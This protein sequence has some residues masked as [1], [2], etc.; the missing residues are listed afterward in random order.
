MNLVQPGLHF[1]FII[2]PKSGSN[3]D[4]KAVGDLVAYLRGQQCSVSINLTKSLDHAGELAAAAL[5]APCAAIITAGGDG[6]VR[7]VIAAIAGSQT[8]L[9]IIPAG[10]ENLLATELGIDPSFD[11]LVELLER[12]CLKTLD[13]G[14]ADGSH[15]MAILGVGFDAEV[16]HRMNRFR[17]GHITHYDYIWPISRTF[18]EYRFPT[19]K[20]EADGR[21][22][23][24]EPAL[25]F[26]SNIS[27]YSVGLGISPDADCGDGFLDITIYRCRTHAR[28][29]QH[30]FLTSIRR[31][32]QSPFITRLRCQCA[33]IS[34]PDP[35]THVQIDGDPGPALPIDIRVM[36]AAAH[37][38]GP[39]G[40][41]K[42]RIS[43]LH[44]VR[45]WLTR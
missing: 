37:I 30:A 16:I 45:R 27:R 23:C 7:A 41:G 42:H 36:P 10:T 20:V 2:N 43:R 13:L 24:D 38:L 35:N 17:A 1:E 8:P 3:L 25:V 29:L 19:I 28:L 18:W 15:F 9:L 6:T 40:E 11:T 31:A 21:S 44:Y 14:A 34:S 5:K 4:I 33:T 39:A 22:I 26:V 32:D 12:P